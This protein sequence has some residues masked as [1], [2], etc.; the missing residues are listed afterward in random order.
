MISE[1]RILAAR[2]NGAKSRGPKTPQGKAR[3]RFAVRTRRLAESNVLSVEPV[4]TFTELFNLNVDCFAPCNQI[5]IGL[6]EEMTSAYWR[7]R[8]GWAIE[9]YLLDHTV[10]SESEG[11]S[12][13]RLSKAYGELLNQ[14]QLPNLRREETRLSAMF[15]RALYSLIL[16]RTAKFRIEP[17]KSFDCNTSSKIEEPSEPNEPKEPKAA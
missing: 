12:M 8:R 1:K 10:Q 14:G 6:I 16:M 4:D 13:A 15:Q 7:L 3:S 11:D 17:K 9:N 5:E 2:A